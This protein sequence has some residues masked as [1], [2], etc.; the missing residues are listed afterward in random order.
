MSVKQILKT[1][2]PKC[3]LEKR[4]EYYK[5]KKNMFMDEIFL[6]YTYKKKLGFKNNLENIEILALG[7]SHADYALLTES[8]KNIF[9]LGLT[10]LD[11][12]SSY[13]LYEKYSPR[14]KNLKNIIFFYSVFTPGFSL[15]KTEEKYRLVAY[16]YFFGIQYQENEIINQKVE[17]TIINKCKKIKEIKID[18]DYRGYSKKD[19]FFFGM[20]A[21]ERANT[22]LRE[23]RRQPNQLK[24]LEKFIY[25][26][27]EDNRNLY[28]VISPAQKSYIECLPS[29][30]KLFNEIYNIKNDNVIIIDFYDSPLFSDFDFGDFDHLNENGAKKLT[31]EILKRIEIYTSK[32]N[33]NK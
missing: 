13:K 6:S 9:N 19:A 20:T 23:N 15:I 30:F 3:L 27:R 11:M 2:L 12:Y 21:E 28:I 22:H 24:W 4:A 26:A 10:S 32:N 7:S 18:K 29:K 25:M 14:M 33:V 1:F 17:K 16:K 8:N 31:A 5:R